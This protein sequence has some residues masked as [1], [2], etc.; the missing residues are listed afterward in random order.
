MILRLDASSRDGD[1]SG[2]G[3]PLA[4]GGT[5][6]NTSLTRACVETTGI[7]NVIVALWV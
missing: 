6:T 4:Y 3:S 7:W 1:G 2:Q 5:A